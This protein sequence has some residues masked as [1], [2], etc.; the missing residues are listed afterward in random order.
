MDLHRRSILTGLVAAAA[1]PICLASSAKASS[2]GAR[3]AYDGAEGPEHWGDLAPDFKACSLGTQQSPINLPRPVYAHLSPLSLRWRPLPLTVVNNGHTIEIPV[4]GDV[5]AAEAQAEDFED[6]TQE[7]GQEAGAATTSPYGTASEGGELFTLKQFHFHHPSEHRID[8]RGLAMEIHFVHVNRTSTAAL[9][10]GVFVVAGTENPT[11]ETIWRAMPK[12]VGET[13]TSQRIHPAHLL[14]E[15]RD[16]FRYEGS[17]TTPPCSE[18]VQWNLFR[19]P[20]TASKAQIETFAALFPNN[21]RS[22]LPLNRR[23]VLQD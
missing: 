17:L 7:A 4:P 11:L 8:G 23:F 2:A 19:R 21:A 15:Q 9:V 1:C 14:P 12:T 3:W 5:F 10:V 16:R 18:I 22:V 6:V 13:R 20:I